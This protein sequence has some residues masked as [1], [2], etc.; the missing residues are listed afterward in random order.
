MRGRGSGRSSASSREIGLE[1]PSAA[2]ISAQ[3]ESPR[4][5]SIVAAWVI[6][7]TRPP[8]PK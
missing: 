1:S 4:V 5:P 2:A 3:R 6:E 7:R 8:K